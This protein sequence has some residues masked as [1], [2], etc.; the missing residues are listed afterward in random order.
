V[1]LE[2]SKLVE[3]ADAGMRLAALRA[4]AHRRIMDAG[5]LLVRRIED[6]SF[7]DL[8]S[9]EREALLL[10]LSA[11]NPTR[12]ESLA[13]TLIAPQGVIKREAREQTRAVAARYLADNARTPEGIAALEAA[14]KKSWL[15]SDE[16]QAIAEAGLS[17]ARARVGGGS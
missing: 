16:V 14:A 7:H 13:A 15:G 4:M 17:A 6:P 10:A 8:A 11:L 1:K 5:P 2:L 3:H 12:A 9:D